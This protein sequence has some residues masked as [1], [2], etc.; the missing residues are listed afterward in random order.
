LFCNR[1]TKQ[2]K[3][4]SQQ[5]RHFFYKALNVEH[6]EVL[7]A[8]VQSRGSAQFQNLKTSENGWEKKR[9]KKSSYTQNPWEKES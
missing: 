8:G 7:M 5:L 2:N 9:L 3:L 4:R 1:V 6:L